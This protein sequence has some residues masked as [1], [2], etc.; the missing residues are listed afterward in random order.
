MKVEIATPDDYI[1]DVTGDLSRRRGSIH[2]MRRFR[3]GSQ[4][5]VGS[6]PLSEMFGYA[7]TLR[8]LSSGRA[9]FSMEFLA[10]EPI[11][12]NLVEGVLEKVR[13]QREKRLADKK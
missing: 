10:F 13:Q 11:P 2:T 3:K 7:T 4:K 6:V 9:N 1:G 5:L 8:S 12:A